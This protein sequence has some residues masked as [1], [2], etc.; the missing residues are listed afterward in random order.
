MTTPEAEAVGRRD[1]GPRTDPGPRVVRLG[2][3]LLDACGAV[4]RALRGRWRPVNDHLQ[5][6]ATAVLTSTGRALGELDPDDRTHHVRS[7]LRSCGECER[8]LR[9]LEAVEAIPA[10]LSTEGLRCVRDIRA[11]LF[12]LVPGSARART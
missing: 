3:R 8:C 10:A 7:A 2:E 5:R 1:R 9:G 11:A 4:D 6:A 12:R